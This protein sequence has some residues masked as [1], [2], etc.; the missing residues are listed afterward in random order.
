L[1]KSDRCLNCGEPAPGQFCSQ[2]GQKNTHYRVSF[3]ELIEEVV[4]ELFQLDSR[5]GRTVVPF[6]FR[7]GKLTGEF[8]AGRR[9]KYSSPLRLYLLTSFVY[10]LTLSLAQPA[11]SFQVQVSADQRGSKAQRTLGDPDWNNLSPDARKELLQKQT[12]SLS[13]YGRLGNRLRERLVEMA[14]LDQQQIDR[15]LSPGIADKMSKAM[16]LLLPLFALL[17][18]GLFLGSGRFYIEHFVF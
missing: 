11:G 7:P 17:L 8:I 18:K 10:F 9:T 3:G 6:L 5:I 2:C 1:H 12:A 13:K 16:F 14:Q 4:G 15:K